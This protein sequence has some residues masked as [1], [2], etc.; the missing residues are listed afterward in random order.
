MTKQI[1]VT[2]SAG[3]IGF[4]LV[5][6]LLSKGYTVIGIDNLNDYYDPKLKLRRLDNLNNFVLGNDLSGQYQ[7]VKLDIADACDLQDLFEQ[8]EFDIVIN[9]AAQAG[10]RYSIENPAVYVSS[11]LVGFA[12]ILE[13][14]RKSRIKHL[15]F[16]SSSSVYG[17]N[18]KQPF[19]ESDNTE[20][21]VS[22]YAATK[23]SNELLAYSYSHLYGIPV[24][25]LRFFTV[26]GPFGRPD[27]AY[28]LFTK[29]IDE[30]RSILVNNG[31]EM[32]RDF[33]YIDDIVEG[34]LNLVERPPD[35]VGSTVSNSLAPYSILNIGNNDPVTLMRFI[36]AIEAALGKS[37]VMS[38]QGMQAGD[39]PITYADI[40]NINAMIGFS[41][42]T[43]IEDGILK[44]VEWYRANS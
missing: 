6:S 43:S 16:A 39:V 28:Y 44:F 32:K 31:G 11:N 14:C 35:T 27:M 29:A 40:D 5:K 13:C 24:T 9:L 25:G 37:A 30:G 38:M 20:H 42:K 33:T 3:F 2:G 7:F 8:Y 26:Y 21:P 10:V 34:I 4:H 23:K 22:L 19:S 15:L 17:M 41:P 12:N 36:Q 18:K 1:L